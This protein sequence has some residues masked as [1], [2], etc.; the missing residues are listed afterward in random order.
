MNEVHL[1]HSFI[2]SCLNIDWLVA[3]YNLAKVAQNYYYIEML[4]VILAID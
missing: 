2:G 1:A 3:D 4:T